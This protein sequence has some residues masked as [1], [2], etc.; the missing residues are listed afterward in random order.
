[1][2]LNGYPYTDFHELNLDWLIKEFTALKT[3]IEQFVAINALKYADPIQWNITRQ[4]EKNTIVI[5]PLTGTAYISVQPVPSGVA[6]TR[7]EY[8][9][10]V[11]DL[12]SFVTRA[13]QNFTGRWES[14]TTTTATFATNTGEWL[15]WGDVLYKALSNIIAGD[16]YVVGSNI[17]HFT[18]EDLYNAY[19]DTISSILEMIGDLNELTTTDKSSIVNAINSLVSV[20]TNI[21]EFVGTGPLATS[22][23]ILSGAIN[24][25]VNYGLAEPYTPIQEGHLIYTN[26]DTNKTTKVYYAIIDKKYKPRLVMAGE[27]LKDANNNF[28]VA[29]VGAVSVREKA[30]VAI[31]AST[32]HSSDT[33]SGTIIIDGVVKHIN[34]TSYAEWHTYDLENLY[35]TEDGILHV[36]DTF[37]SIDDMLA[38]NPVWSFNGWQAIYKNGSIVSGVRDDYLYPH[39]DIAQDINGNYLVM[40]CGGREI[41]NHGMDYADVVDCIMNKI[42]FNAVLIYGCDGGGSSSLV[43][44]Q[45]RQNGLVENE[46][47]KV[48]T[49][50]VFTAENA[51]TY[52]DYESGYSDYLADIEEKKLKTTINSTSSYPNITLVGPNINTIGLQFYSRVSAGQYFDYVQLM[53]L[54][55]DNANHRMYID[56]LN[57]SDQYH[58]I[59]SLDESNDHAKLIGKEVLRGSTIKQYSGTQTTNA[60]GA[61]DSNTFISG[62]GIPSTAIILDVIAPDGDG[63]F[64][65]YIYNNRYWFY[66]KDAGSWTNKTNREGTI[67]ITWMTS[68]AVTSIT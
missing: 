8:W 65:P 7:T 41:Y 2:F 16:T 5:D 46:V 12:G 39:T 68:P 49:M 13:A 11:F 51:H 27:T 57:G 60:S 6:L 67:R 17:E 54:G 48:P 30:T 63:V 62:G 19:L 10:V 9:T 52:S 25:I 22:S 64:I 66:K 40:T 20:T 1:M 3:A 58:N 55:Y 38:L 42:G 31:N 53:K 59:L 26:T 35:M 43:T 18:M 36:I 47:R 44:H 37:A 61:L 28:I 56:A 45:I 24:E 29:D 33:T 50:L 23:Q 34:D 4:Y 15:V 21:Y 32:M 14:E